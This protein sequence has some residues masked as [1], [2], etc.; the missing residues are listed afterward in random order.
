[1]GGGT[2]YERIKGF[3]RKAFQR[4][5]LEY[6]DDESDTKP[7][8]EYPSLPQCQMKN[9]P[10]TLEPPDELVC[11]IS[12]VLMTNDPVLAADGI[13]YERSSIEDWFK[14]SKAKGS[15]VYSPVHG[16]E[17]ESMV[18]MPNIGIRNMARAFKDK[19]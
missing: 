17:M 16:T 19:K 5:V 18:L 8:P 6:F 4:A 14:K 7:T 1:M 3:K 12:L 2:I 11:P 15:V 10:E 9:Q 13:T